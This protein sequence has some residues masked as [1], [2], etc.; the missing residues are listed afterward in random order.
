MLLMVTCFGV[1]NF[2]LAE[3]AAYHHIHLRVPDTNVAAA[4][5]AKYT[6]GEQLKFGDFDVV[7]QNNEVLIIFSPNERPG[8]DGAIFEGEILGSVGT[9][10]DHI[11]FS[12]AD[13]DAQMSIYKEAGI[14][15]LQEPK[16][17]GG[18]F[19]YAFIEDPWGTKIEV[20]QDP[21]LI[22]IHHIHLMS[23]NPVETLNWYQ[24]QFGGEITAFKDIPVL[25][26]IIYSGL[27]LIASKV[28]LAVS[29]TRFRSID[30]LG[31]GVQNIEEQMNRYSKNG[32]TLAAGIKSVG[33]FK[34]AFVESPE[35]VLVE[36]VQPPE[37]TN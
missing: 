3:N 34:I 22:G 4:W 33:D 37:N 7:R 10:V 23:T 29:T 6:A 35:G 21:Q 31:F 14:T 17:V 19:S 2:V 20:M 16:Q 1:S 36:I 24:T 11:G 8:V 5:Y 30:H 13:L 12:F 9:G 32:V 28:D 27:W 18:L 15:I 25:P 26:S